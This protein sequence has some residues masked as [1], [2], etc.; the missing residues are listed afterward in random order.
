MCE[1]VKDDFTSFSLNYFSNFLATRSINNEEPLKDLVTPD[2]SLLREAIQN[3]PISDVKSLI[4]T[5]TRAD[6]NTLSHTGESAIHRAATE[7]DIDGNRIMINY[8]ANVNITD[9][10]GFQPV[11]QA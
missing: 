5:D 9:K 1:N 11:H 4:Q 2:N 6:I 3:K 10:H 7:G 8:G